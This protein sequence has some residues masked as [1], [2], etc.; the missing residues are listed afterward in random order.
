[1]QVLTAVLV[2]CLMAFPGVGQSQE[3][4][5]EQ[6]NGLDA[7][8]LLRKARTSAGE[9]AP[10][11]NGAAVPPAGLPATGHNTTFHP[12]AYNIWSLNCHTEANF[13]TAVASARGIPA[14]I[15]VCQGNPETSPQF[16]T[17]NW[18]IESSGRTC[19]YNWGEACCWEASAS[20]PDINTGPGQKCA[21]A[22]CAAQYDPNQTRAMPSGKLVESP[23]PQVCAV[24]AAGGPLTLLP[25]MA[26]S[27]VSERLR[28]G[29][30]SVRVPPY[31]SLPEGA[32][33]TFT[34]DRLSACL[35]CCS[36]RA[37]LWSGLPAASVTPNLAN[38]REAQFRMQCLSVC[39]N[40]FT[41]AGTDALRRFK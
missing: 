4:S 13:F 3:N 26:I 36:Q 33:M 8:G 31:P 25:G 21:Q 24:G 32:V 6:L 5:F 29:A 1:M 17:A 38:G 15:L 37:N 10:A 28:T 35:D 7:G 19:I 14:G 30:E 2:L 11:V 16:H 20:P 12:S 23:G 39:R 34:P 9:Q 40:A 18:A 27:A 41:S 22:A